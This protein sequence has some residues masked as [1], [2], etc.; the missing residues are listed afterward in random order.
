MKK[1][2]MT[3]RTI[4]NEEGYIFEIENVN[5]LKSLWVHHNALGVK[6]FVIGMKATFDYMEWY[7]FTYWQDIIKSYEEFVDEDIPKF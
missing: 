7:V 2:K 5:G 4:R 3:V 1:T 6:M